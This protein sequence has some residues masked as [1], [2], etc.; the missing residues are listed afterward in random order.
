MSALP[1]DCLPTLEPG[2]RSRITARFMAPR[3]E[4]PRVRQGGDSRAGDRSPRPSGDVCAEP[5]R[6][7]VSPESRGVPSSGTGPS[8]NGACSGGGISRKIRTGR[9]SLSHF[10]FGKTR[11]CIHA[12]QSAPS[13][14]M[15]CFGTTAARSRIMVL[16]I[17]CEIVYA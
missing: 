12:S 11:V 10:R 4:A 16:F 14:R 7:K 8:Q 3:H 13:E 5:L 15:G 6:L 9:N 2:T 17:D 1:Y